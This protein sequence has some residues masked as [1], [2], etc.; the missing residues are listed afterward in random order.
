MTRARPTAY[1][2]VGGRGFLR[3]RPRGR[4]TGISAAASGCSALFFAMSASRI[5]LARS[6]MRW[7]ARS[8]AETMTALGLSPGFAPNEPLR[9]RPEGG[10]GGSESTLLSTRLGVS[11][12]AGSVTFLTSAFSVFEL[13]SGAAIFLR[14][15]LISASFSASCC[16]SPS[17]L[18]YLAT[19]ALNL[20]F[21]LR[22][23]WARRSLLDGRL[24]P[25]CLFP[26]KFF[27][28]LSEFLMISSSERP[29][30][31]GG[32]SVI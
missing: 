24:A 28:L 7:R 19:S 26:M 1:S 20:A 27:S 32:T 12:A 31:S 9:T 21:S 10:L 4:L 23:F 15:F 2:A 6:S 13:A 22:S 30:N 17:V 3:G 14:I 16:V 11:G 25:L 5:F 18:L 29:R 8:A